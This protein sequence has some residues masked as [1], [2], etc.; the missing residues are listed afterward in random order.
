M[1]DTKKTTAKGPNRAQEKCMLFL[2]LAF[3]GGVVLYSVIP[4]GNTRVLAMI[5]FSSAILYLMYRYAF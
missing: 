4:E 5:G 3:V 1:S 2:T